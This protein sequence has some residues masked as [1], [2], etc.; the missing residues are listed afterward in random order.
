MKKGKLG[1][2]KRARE[3]KVFRYWDMNIQERE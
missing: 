1:E 3:G 2:R